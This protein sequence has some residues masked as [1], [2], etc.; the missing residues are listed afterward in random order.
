MTRVSH[1]VT[2]PRGGTMP[3]CQGTGSLVPGK[4]P[5]MVFGA[6]EFIQIFRSHLS[7]PTGNPAKLVME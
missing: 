1:E 3:Q 7:L 5:E 6:I 2:S 4:L